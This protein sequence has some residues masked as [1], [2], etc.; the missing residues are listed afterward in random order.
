MVATVQSSNLSTMSPQVFVS[1]NGLRLLGAASSSSLRATVSVSIPG[2]QAGQTYLVRASGNAAGSSTGGF[3]L[4]LNFG[5]VYQPPIA[6]PNTVVLQQPDQGG[7]GQEAAVG[8]LKIGNVT[9]LGYM[10][11]GNLPDNGSGVIYVP[12]NPLQ[13][14]VQTSVDQSSATD[15]SAAL[16]AGTNIAQPQSIGSLVSLAATGSQNSSTLDSGSTPSVLQLVDYLI[17]N[18]NG[19]AGLL[20]STGG[21]A[22]NGSL[23][24]N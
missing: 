13:L 4:E 22:S 10:L 8:L 5:S 2:V 16:V 24:G 18:W 20:A 9:A 19:P 21:N 14:S 3:G 7:G 17:M 6:P 15:G 12:L 23:P 1:T 11:S